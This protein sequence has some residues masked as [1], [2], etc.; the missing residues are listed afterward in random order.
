MLICLKVDFYKFKKENIFQLSDD[1]PSKM[2][3]NWE[4][5]LT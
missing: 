5:G 1:L 4:A 3:I 2:F